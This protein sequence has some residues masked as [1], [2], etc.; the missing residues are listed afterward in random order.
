MK[1]PSVSLGRR[2]R[3]LAG[4]IRWNLFCGAAAATLLVIA[5]VAGMLA[6]QYTSENSGYSQGAPVFRFESHIQE[7]PGLTATLTLMGSRYE[8]SFA[9]LN[10]LAELGQKYYL[11]LPPELR[12]TRQLGQLAADLL[13]SR[14]VRQREQDFLGYCDDPSRYQ[15][16]EGSTVYGSRQ[17]LSGNSRSNAVYLKARP[18]P[19]P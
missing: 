11:L 12:L 10:Q 13:D 9:P 14:R 2:L 15:E 19:L 4:G 7:E 16:P 1:Q 8:L 3:R 17:D 5:F 18:D 6:V